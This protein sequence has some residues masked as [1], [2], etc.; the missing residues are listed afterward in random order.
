MHNGFSMTLLV[1][2]FF[3][4]N[5]ILM[6]LLI[7]M[8]AQTYEDREHQAN[9]DSLMDKYYLLEEHTRRAVSHPPP[10]N[11]I[12][13]FV[14]SIS[15]FYHETSHKN[16]DCSE[17]QRFL[18]YLSRNFPYGDPPEDSEKDYNH[19]VPLYERARTSVLE[20]EDVSGDKVL[21]KNLQKVKEDVLN[22]YEVLRKLE[23]TRN[24]KLEHVKSS[25]STE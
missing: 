20:E 22:V 6:N 9:R 4:G 18:I 16:L 14:E 19:F 7:A 11:I 12:Y 2:V 8:M 24:Q 1:L 3:L 13:F 23:L 21:V 17:F 5:V 10:I 15:F 25:G